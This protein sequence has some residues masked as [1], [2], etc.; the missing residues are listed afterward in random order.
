M[1]GSEFVLGGRDVVGFA[2]HALCL[3]SGMEEEEEEG[4]RERCVEG[5]IIVEVVVTAV[6]DSS[7]S[8][9]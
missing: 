9:S 4:G 7:L 5:M 2:R 6:T 1:R 3:L 8:L